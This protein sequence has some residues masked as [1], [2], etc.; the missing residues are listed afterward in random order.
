MIYGYTTYLDNA[1]VNSRGSRNS[2]ASDTTG[3]RVN[4]V[5]HFSKAVRNERNLD[6]QRVAA[7]A[8]LLGI[9]ERIGFKLTCAPGCQTKIAGYYLEYQ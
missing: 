2:G 6:P 8:T 3:L 1:F 7:G 5:Q 4:F 9:A